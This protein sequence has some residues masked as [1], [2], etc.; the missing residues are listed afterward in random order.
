MKIDIALLATT[1]CGSEQKVKVERVM[2]W[3]VI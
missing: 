3:G 2:Q 1:V